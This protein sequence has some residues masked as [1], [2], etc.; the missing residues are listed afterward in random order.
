MFVH[1][2]DFKIPL[3]RIGIETTSPMQWWSPDGWVKHN[4]SDR[5]R[6]YGNVLVLRLDDI[7]TTD[8]EV[9]DPAPIW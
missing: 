8:Y 6:N 4:F 9:F 3:G 7:D 1:L 2:D 5:L